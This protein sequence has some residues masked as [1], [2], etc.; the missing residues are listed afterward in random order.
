MR[1]RP[2]NPIRTSP[3]EIALPERRC[4]YE[5]RGSARRISAH[6]C[7]KQT[8]HFGVRNKADRVRTQ[9]IVYISST[10]YGG[11][12]E[13]NLIRRESV[14]SLNALTKVSAN[15]VNHDTGPSHGVPQFFFRAIEFLA[16]ITHRPSLRLTPLR[17]VVHSRVNDHTAFAY[18]FDL[19]SVDGADIRR[20]PLTE[21][22]GRLAKLLRKAKPG[23]RLSEHIE[24][25][26]ATVFAHA[27]KLGLEGIVSK[28]VDAPYR[29]GRARTWIK[30]KNQN[31]PAFLRVQEGA[32]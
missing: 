15:L 25:D 6:S 26:G 16:P 20:V 22:R 32:F 24:A 7:Q 30:V 18:A 9:H 29:S 17:S 19:L 13:I 14:A 1:H 21:R 4:P 5:R 8:L 2:A 3:N 27:C 11:V 28:R 10:F 23:V 31:A 12:T